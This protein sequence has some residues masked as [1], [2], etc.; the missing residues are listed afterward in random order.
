MRVSRRRYNRS[1]F[2]SETNNSQPN[3][4]P[5][6]LLQSWFALF[7]VRG[8]ELWNVEWVLDIC[9]E[10]YRYYEFL[11]VGRFVPGT[12]TRFFLLWWRRFPAYITIN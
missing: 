11:V 1:L 9:D 7:E 3:V 8:V 5:F 2:Q 4:R 10:K 12:S 6:D